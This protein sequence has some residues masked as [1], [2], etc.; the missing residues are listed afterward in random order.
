M[1]DFFEISL[2]WLSCIAGLSA[3][4]IVLIFMTACMSAF[5]FGYKDIAYIFYGLF[6]G[7]I[8]DR[9]CRRNK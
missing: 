3:L 4:W 5:D 2:I 9:I 6:A 1:K 8:L 7:R